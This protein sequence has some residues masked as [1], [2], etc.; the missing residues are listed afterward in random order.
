MWTDAAADAPR[1]P[2]SG[3]P[4][5]PAA[6]LSA[7]APDGYPGGRALCRVCHRFIPLTDEGTLSPHDTFDPDETDAET[8]QRQEWIN[9]HGW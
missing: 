5:L 3:E 4:A 6:P 9:T 8:A 7:D 2:A 1:C